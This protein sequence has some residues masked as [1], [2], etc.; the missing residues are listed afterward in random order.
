M[1]QKKLRPF[2]SKMAYKPTR[3]TAWIH[4]DRIDIIGNST[5]PAQ[6]SGVYRCVPSV[7]VGRRPSII[8]LGWYSGCQPTAFGF[9]TPL[10]HLRCTRWRLQ[11]HYGRLERL[12]ID[13]NAVK[14]PSK[15]PRCVGCGDWWCTVPQKR[16]S[17]ILSFRNDGLF[18][19]RQWCAPW[20]DGVLPGHTIVGIPRS[21]VC[22]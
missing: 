21:W 1:L 20:W 15:M 18:F 7:K 6:N 8:L 12:L 3:G 9:I 22:K 10:V 16:S 4:A 2:L 11:S 5:A 13:R 14:L 17:Y 19:L